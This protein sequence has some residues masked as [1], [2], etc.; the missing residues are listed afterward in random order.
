MKYFIVFVLAAILAMP[1]AAM[2]Q[3]RVNEY[4]EEIQAENPD[5][6]EQVAP[7]TPKAVQPKPSSNAIVEKAV[8]ADAKPPASKK[9]EKTVEVEYKSYSTSEPVA[10]GRDKKFRAGFVG[11]GY[12][13][14]NR[15]VN[16]L[17]TLGV[18]G[19]YFFFER[20]SAVMRMEVATKFKNPAILT[21]TPRARYVFDLDRHPRWALYAQAG[22]GLGLYMGGGTYAAADIAIPGGGF[23]WQW[24]DK[25]SFGGDTSL[26]IFVR[27]G[28]AVGFTIAPVV[29]YVF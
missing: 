20:L 4:G 13:F 3:K 15:G 21:L 11:P 23:W 6:V 22:I 26:H 8:P 25:W 12:G 5:F 27:D 14:V 16:S 1:S 24:T 18:E 2:A 28:A 9:T 10:Y 29:R 7:T 19:E 17:M